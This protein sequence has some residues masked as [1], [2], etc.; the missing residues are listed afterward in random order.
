MAMLAFK[1][2][3]VGNSVGFILPKEAQSRLKVEKGDTIYA[4]EAPDGSYR[5]TAHDVEFERQMALA[6]KIM[7]DDRDILSVLAKS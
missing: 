2:T 5:L 3:T 4:T 7:H 1:L 6:E